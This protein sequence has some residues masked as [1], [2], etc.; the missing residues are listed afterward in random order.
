MDDWRFAPD[1]RG[2]REILK[3]DGVRRELRRCA[4]EICEKANAHAEAHAGWLREGRFRAKSYG[5]H[6][7]EGAYTAIGAVHTRHSA[8][9][10]NEARNKSL[11]RQL[12]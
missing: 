7:D 6:V 4:D 11:G 2:V 1:V 5:V 3:S 10:V 9:R 12:H 8:A